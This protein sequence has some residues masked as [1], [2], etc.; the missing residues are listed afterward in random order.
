MRK[1]LISYE[2]VMPLRKSCEQGEKHYLNVKL[3]VKED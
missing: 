3:S 2:K 1:T